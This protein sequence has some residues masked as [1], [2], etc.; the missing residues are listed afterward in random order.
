MQ[1]ESPKRTYELRATLLGSCGVGINKS[2]FTSTLLD[3]APDEEEEC[4]NE[5]EEEGLLY[6]YNSDEDES[7]KED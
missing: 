1:A 2:Y 5:D 4:D 7:G 3:T 6:Y